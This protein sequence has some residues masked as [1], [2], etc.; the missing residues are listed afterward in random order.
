MKIYY[1]LCD[2]S[3]VEIYKSHEVSAA[4]KSS[5]MWNV[6]NKTVVIG[7]IFII[8]DHF[9]ISYLSCIGNDKAE[10]SSWW[11]L[12]ISLPGPLIM[13]G[14][15]ST[16]KEGKLLLLQICSLNQTDVFIQKNICICCIFSICV[17]GCIR[18]NTSKA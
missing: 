17:G 11:F 15:F 8:M 3:F 7:S 10:K 16:Q 9:A 12:F 18:L 4:L 6:M 14:S 13:T 5:Y 1:F 2:H